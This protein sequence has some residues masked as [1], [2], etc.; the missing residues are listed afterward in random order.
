MHFT[1]V[2]AITDRN[3]MGMYKQDLLDFNKS[4]RE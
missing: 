3:E 2:L 1:R 4:W